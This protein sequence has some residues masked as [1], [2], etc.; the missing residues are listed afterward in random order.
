MTPSAHVLHVISTPF[1]FR[2]IPDTG[3]SGL[4]NVSAK[5]AQEHPSSANRLVTE[6]LW[7]QWSPTGLSCLLNFIKPGSV[8]LSAF[9]NRHDSGMNLKKADRMVWLGRMMLA[10][11]CPCCRHLIFVLVFPKIWTMLHFSRSDHR[12][13]FSGLRSRILS[14]VTV[15]FCSIII[16]IIIIIIILACVNCHSLSATPRSVI[17]SPPV[18]RCEQSLVTAITR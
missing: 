11:P 17:R 4:R 15:N 10:I 16:I 8:D 18:I 9:G 14:F 5:P 13:S 3:V 12:A 2:V 7:A 6:N 1:P